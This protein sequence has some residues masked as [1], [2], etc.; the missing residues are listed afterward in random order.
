[1]LWNRRD[2]WHWQHNLHREQAT[3]VLHRGLIN[4]HIFT[5]SDELKSIPCSENVRLIYSLCPGK[6][7]LKHVCNNNQQWSV[8][9]QLVFNSD[10]S[11]NFKSA[12]SKAASPL[13]WKPSPDQKLVL[14]GSSICVHIYDLSQTGNWLHSYFWLL[15]M[16][17][18]LE[19]GAQAFL[20]DVKWRPLS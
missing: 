10:Q 5:L 8:P 18:C 14:I 16:T 3:E 1:M 20:C 13:G 15:T 2:E 4:W 17:R 7:L 12:D 19:F 11:I 6:H 9:Q